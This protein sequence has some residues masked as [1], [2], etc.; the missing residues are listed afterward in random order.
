MT[1]VK[2]G[3][4]VYFIN[5]GCMV[6]ADLY[7][8]GGVN[9]IKWNPGSLEY[10]GNNDNADYTVTWSSDQVWYRDDLAVAVVPADYFYIHPQRI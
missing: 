4:N 9:I 2:T 10:V 6:W 1:C 3:C 5:Y 8:V 7:Q